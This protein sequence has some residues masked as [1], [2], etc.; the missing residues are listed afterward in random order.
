MRIEA[1]LDLKHGQ[2]YYEYCKGNHGLYYEVFVQGRPKIVAEGWLEVPAKFRTVDAHTGI[3]VKDVDLES[4]EWL[5]YNVA[6]L[7]LWTQVT[8]C[9]G[10]AIRWA[11]G[12]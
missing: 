10:Q 6:G 12:G 5:C 7:D 9:R 2:V 8:R 1:L 4:E 3:V 11:R